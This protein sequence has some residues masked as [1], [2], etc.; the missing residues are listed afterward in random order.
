[1]YNS[2]N[3][4]SSSTSSSFQEQLEG[5]QSGEL[6]Q[7]NTS[8]CRA[9]YDYD[10][11]DPSALSFRRGDIIEILTRQPSGWW[12]GLLGEERGWFPSN[13][14]VVISE[15]EAEAVFAQAEIEA[16]AAAVAPIRQ[17]PALANDLPA[18]FRGIQPEQEKWLDNELGQ[19]SSNHDAHHTTQNGV[20][21]SDFWM[22]EVTPD[23][24]VFCSPCHLCQSLTEHP[25]RYIM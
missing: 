13:Y 15:A 5:Q 19:V 2:R 16:Q 9:L 18:S 20:Q 11:Q 4:A 3:S 12:D 22:P 25:Q 8:F 21:P 6:Q 23:G 1:M 17:Q 14:V 10:A 24:Q 7:F